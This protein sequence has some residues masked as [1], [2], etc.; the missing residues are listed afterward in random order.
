MLTYPAQERET[1]HLR[2]HDIQEDQVGGYLLKEVKRIHRI[3]SE[4]DFY[5]VE[6]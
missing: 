1:V 4:E 2:H 6:F 5:A 3:V